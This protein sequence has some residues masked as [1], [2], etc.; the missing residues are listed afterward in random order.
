V[1]FF[2]H[3]RKYLKHQT[4]SI[5]M[6]VADHILVFRTNVSTERQAVDLCNQ[7]YLSGLVSRATLDM[8]DCDRILRVETSVAVASE[9]ENAV[10]KMNISIE[11]LN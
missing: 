5:P 8:E 9:I 11:E 10:R 4:H 1:E 3:I 2:Y 7:L 6:V